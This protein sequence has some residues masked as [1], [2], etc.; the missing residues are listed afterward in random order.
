M[1]H[2]V[3]YQTYCEGYEYGSAYCWILPLW[4]ILLVSICLL[5][6]LTGASLLLCWYCNP[7]TRHS[8]PYRYRRAGKATRI[9]HA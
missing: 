9:N 8:R 6:L 5:L 7:P 3:L 1:R 2:S 4:A